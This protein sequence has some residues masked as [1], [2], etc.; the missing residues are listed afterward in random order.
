MDDACDNRLDKFVPKLSRK[1]FHFSEVEDGSSVLEFIRRFV[2]LTDQEDPFFAV[3][4]GRIFHLYNRWKEL[5]P[6]V[7]IFYGKKLVYSS[8]N[9]CVL[10]VQ[11]WFN[12]VRIGTTFILRIY[13]IIT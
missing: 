3:D 7:D 9:P 8:M 1:S 11:M 6:R 5:L 10:T 13:D 2:T 4:L 12:C